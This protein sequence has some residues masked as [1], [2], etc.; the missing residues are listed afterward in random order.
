MQPVTTVTGIACPLGLAN[1]DTDQ[2]IPARFMV[3]SRAEGYGRCL[4]HD[5]RFDAGGV[6]NADFALN[7]PRF[8]AAP[9]LVA[10]GN[11]GSGS[12]RE[13]AV[14]A[15]WDF[16]VRCVI[17]PSFGDIFASNATKNGLLTATIGE[18][19]TEALLDLLS[20]KGAP[21]VT[22]DL[23]AQSITTGD[24]R[25]TFAIDPTRRLQL[26]EGW[27][28]IDLTLRHRAAIDAF[29]RTLASTRPWAVPT[30]RSAIG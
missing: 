25:I 4:F 5:L 10:R 14:Y 19:E 11:F 8:T 28:D 1:V 17:A 15:L 18:A 26:L 24:L 9:V 7:Q 30:P 27:D 3:R 16:G 12:S 20:A 29:K 2:I 6:P 13:A 23:A 21:E 22:V